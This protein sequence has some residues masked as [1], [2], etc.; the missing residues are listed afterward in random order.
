VEKLIDIPA[1]IDFIDS[2]PDYR[3]DLYAHQKMKSTPESALQF[4][5]A[6]LPVLN[7]IDIWNEEHI[8]T[9]I[10][11]LITHLKIKTGQLLWPLRIALSG[12][13]STPGG[14][15]EIAYLLGKEETIKRVEE[16]TRRLETEK[17]SG[18]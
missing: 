4:L 16:A 12:K 14:F 3:L 9:A 6:A 15:I 1:Q 8:H 10:F 7:T 5:K 18:F 2:V 11:E 13:Q 17:V